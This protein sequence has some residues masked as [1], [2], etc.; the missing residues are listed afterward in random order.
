MKKQPPST[1][2]H[3]TVPDRFTLIELL[4]VIAIIA[5]LAA[6]LLPALNQAR[7]K[8][9][10]TTCLNNQKQ[11]GSAFAMYANDNTDYVLMYWMRGTSGYSWS[12]C[13]IDEKYAPKAVTLCPSVAPHKFVNDWYSYGGNRHTGDLKNILTQ[14]SP[15]DSAYM[16]FKLDKVPSEE[17]RVGYFI[18]LIGETKLR[19]DKLSTD[20]THSDWQVCVLSRESGTYAPNLCHAGRMNLLR[21]DGR[22]IAVSGKELSANY[23]FKKEMWIG[24]AFIFP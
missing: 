16:V 7:E 6:M 13:L 23:N 15:L 5:I 24:E 14:T 9:R 11:L 17:K 18:P 8:A 12:L 20:A 22:A 3:L 2:S 19:Q 21:S 4:V 1:K 10:A